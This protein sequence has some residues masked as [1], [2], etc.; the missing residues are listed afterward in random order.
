M[1]TIHG[2]WNASPDALT[3]IDAFAQLMEYASQDS[4][5]ALFEP[6]RKP[7]HDRAEAF[8]REL[9]ET[10]PRQLD[11]LVAFA[12]GVYR[13][14]LAEAER[15]ELRSLYRKLRAQELPHDD[16]FRFTLARVFVSPAFLYRPEKSP[17]GSAP[18]P[19]SDWEL[20]SRLSYFLWS[21]MPDARLREVVAAGRLVDPDVLAGEARRMLTD[22]RVRR[23]AVEFAC[24]WLH[25]YDFDT[26]DEKSERHFPS[27][28]YLRGDM[29]E[30]VIR[31]FTDL[32]QLD[33]SILAAFN[34]DYTK[35]FTVHHGRIQA[36]ELK[37]PGP[38]EAEIP[39]RE[40][41]AAIEN[42]VAE[43]FQHGIRGKEVTPF[44]LARLAETTG[45]RSLKSNI[46]LVGNNAG[47]AA[48]VA[49]E[50]ARIQT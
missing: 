4:N 48:L 24:Q 50:F 6:F 43:A 8:R 23:L 22:G 20:A 36:W 7:I 5:P 40:I 16:A 32:A 37:A 2:A 11:A 26:L 34:D 13:R 1:N 47:I 30:E 25:V 42:A 17:P 31:F 9:V 10:E 29:Y 49:A 15:D 27:F 18:R 38:A 45:G 28:A 12:E 19:I 3:L 44:L 33:G 46:A 14:P 35:L 39:A 41:S 21:S